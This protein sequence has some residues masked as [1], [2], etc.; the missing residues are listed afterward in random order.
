MLCPDRLGVNWHKGRNNEYM[1]EDNFIFVIG[2]L[3]NP[4]HVTGALT[5]RANIIYSLS[6][7]FNGP[8]INH[9]ASRRREIVINKIAKQSNNTAPRSFNL[10]FVSG[11]GRRNSI[12][13]SSTARSRHWVCSRIVGH[14]GAK[15]NLVYTL[16]LAGRGWKWTSVVVA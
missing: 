8:I 15:T 16:Y 6:P 11:G 3:L 12:K 1:K 7:E 9:P 5:L 13:P 14:L 4:K 2:I 10:D